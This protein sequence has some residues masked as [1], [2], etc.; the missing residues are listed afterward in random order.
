M[1]AFHAMSKYFPNNWQKFKDAPDEAF[2]T[3]TFEEFCSWK[4]AGWELPES[5]VCIIR[6]EEEG[7]IK[8]YTYQRA[9]YAE[10]RVTQLMRDGHSFSVVDHEAIHHL[11]A[12]DFEFE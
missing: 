2:F 3:P 8:E 7:K 4:L 10:D 11:S 9:C 5:V 6:A 12:E 1:F